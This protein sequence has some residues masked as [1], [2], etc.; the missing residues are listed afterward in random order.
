MQP[1]LMIPIY[2]ADNHFLRYEHEERVHANLQRFDLITNRR[3]H[4][5]EAHVKRDVSFDLRPSSNLG[6]SFLQRLSTGATYSL[7]GVRGSGERDLVGIAARQQLNGCREG[8][9]ASVVCRSGDAEDS[10]RS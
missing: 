6:Q 10:V 7:H 8:M 4:L 9:A 1:R 5:R 2:S 3:G